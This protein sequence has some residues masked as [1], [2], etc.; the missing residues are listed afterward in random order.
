MQQ[1][2]VNPCIFYKEGANAI[3]WVDD[4]LIFAK[5]KAAADELIKDLNQRFTLT[6]E[7]DKSAYLGFSSQCGPQ[8]QY[9]I[10]KTTLSYSKNH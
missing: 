3:L 6:E 10:I 9:N 8:Y 4:C 1:S 2:A 7:D 5:Q